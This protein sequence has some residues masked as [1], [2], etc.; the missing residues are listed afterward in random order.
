MTN[1]RLGL[2]PL[3]PKKHQRWIFVVSYWKNFYLWNWVSVVYTDGRR[4]ISAVGS[5]LWEGWWVVA[6]CT[7]LNENECSE[8]DVNGLEKEKKT[9]EKQQQHTLLTRNPL[10]VNEGKWLGIYDDE[11]E[12]SARLANDRSF[13]IKNCSGRRCL[14][15]SDGD[16]RFVTN[17]ERQ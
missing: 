11:C 15:L 1:G 13:C 7:E 9:S 3:Q 6:K 12:N 17:A 2:I 16:A 10:R 14:L 8:W 4:S 5:W